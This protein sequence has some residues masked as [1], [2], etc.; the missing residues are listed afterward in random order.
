MTAQPPKPAKTVGQT[1]IP[2]LQYALK[3]IPARQAWYGAALAVQRNQSSYAGR[4]GAIAHFG[5]VGDGRTIFF[6]E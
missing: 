6:R 4:K 1:T 2:S 3:V 5:W